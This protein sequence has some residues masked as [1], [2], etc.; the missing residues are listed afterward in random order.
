MKRKSFRLI[1]LE[2]QYTDDAIGVAKLLTKKGHDTVIDTRDIEIRDK[3]TSKSMRADKHVVVTP[4]WKEGQVYVLQHRY[5][6][7]VTNI[8]DL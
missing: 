6:L 2:A 4:K 7:V 5:D 3:F 8:K 1:P